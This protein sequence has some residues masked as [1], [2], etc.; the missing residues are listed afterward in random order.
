MG[1]R[2]ANKIYQYAPNNEANE[3]SLSIEYQKL[4]TG[5]QVCIRN[6]GLLF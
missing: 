4:Q 1:L 6:A 3:D 2:M 5:M